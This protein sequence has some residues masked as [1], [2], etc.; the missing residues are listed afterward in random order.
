MVLAESHIIQQRFKRR[1]DL[2]VFAPFMDVHKA[3]FSGDGNASEWTDIRLAS[4][5]Y[6]TI[7][8]HDVRLIQ[9][10]PRQQVSLH[11][12]PENGTAL[13]INRELPMKGR[14]QQKRDSRVV[15]RQ[16]L[17]PCRVKSFLRSGAVAKN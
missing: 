16:I 13:S 7:F 8:H 10:Q 3:P 6:G 15:S 11:G 14:V 1:V 17:G 9:R 2:E 5:I 12:Q 4:N